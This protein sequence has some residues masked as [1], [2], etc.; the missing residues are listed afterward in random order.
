LERTRL[1]L[2]E[3]DA[4]FHG[5]DIVPTDV[6]EVILDVLDRGELGEEALAAG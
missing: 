3:L 6:V 5:D 2:V 4:F 1:D